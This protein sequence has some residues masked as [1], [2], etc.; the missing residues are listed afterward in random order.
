MS[1]PKRLFAEFLGTFWLVLAGCGSAVFAANFPDLGIGFLGVS[2]AFGLSVLTMVYAVGHISGGHFNPAVSWGLYIGKR[3]E[4]KDLLPYILIQVIAATAAAYL[5]YYIASGN[6]LFDI[7]GGLA[8]NGFGEHSP[9]GYNLL[10]CF[11]AEATMTFMFLIVILGSTDEKAPKGFAALSIGLCLTL[12]NLVAIPI[13]NASINPAR[14]MGPAFVVGG[15]A[16]EQSWL[17]WV[18]PLVGATLAG[19]AYR[20]LKSK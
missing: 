14:T 15:W 2:F 18:A 16:I 6:I 1:L 5:L 10:S 19:L 3:F 9:G 12:A 7:S 11:L 4:A 17:F 8:N 20:F 13:T